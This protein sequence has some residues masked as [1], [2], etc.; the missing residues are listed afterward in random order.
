MT[1]TLVDRGNDQAAINIKTYQDNFQLLA[2]AATEWRHLMEAVVE[3][4]V[5]ASQTSQP[6]SGRNDTTATAAEIMSPHRGGGLG[7]SART[8]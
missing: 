1:Q 2:N 8:G 4:S 6:R 5:A 3:G 7:S